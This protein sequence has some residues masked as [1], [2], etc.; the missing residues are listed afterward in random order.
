MSFDAGGAANNWSVLRGTVA[1]RGECRPVA[2]PTLV[3]VANG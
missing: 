3:A 2:F 1:V